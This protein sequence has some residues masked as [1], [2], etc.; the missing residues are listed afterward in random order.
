MPEFSNRTTSSQE[1]SGL[2]GTCL[3]GFLTPIFFMVWPKTFSRKKTKSPV[4]NAGTARRH[5][6]GKIIRGAVACLTPLF[7]HLCFPQ[8]EKILASVKSWNSWETPAGEIDPLGDTVPH[9]SFYIPQ[10]SKSDFFGATRSGR[11]TVARPENRWKGLFDVGRT[12][13]APFR[14]SPIAFRDRREHFSSFAKKFVV[15]PQMKK[16]PFWY[17]FI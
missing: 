17:L 5:R 2:N 15:R 1:A 4:Q 9:P 3:F 12:I 7:I 16:D 8:G 11:K 6:S 13:E 14:Y 10:A